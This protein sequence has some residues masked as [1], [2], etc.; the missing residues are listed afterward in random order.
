MITLYTTED[1][2]YCKRLKARMDRAGIDYSEVADIEQIRAR[3]YTTVPQMR[4]GDLTYDYYEAID[5]IE[6][7]SKAKEQPKAAAAS[8]PRFLSAEFLSAYPDQ[9]A[10]M[11]PLGAFTYYRTYSRYLPEEGRRETW[12]ETVGRAV[13]YNV[14]LD[15]KH[16]QAQRL[17]LPMAWLKNEAQA[18]FDSIFNL[19]QFPSGRTLWTGNTL[20]SDK[21]PMSNFNCSFTNIEKWSDLAE[22]F[23]LLMLG[24][25]VGF[26]CTPQMAAGLAPIRTDVQLILSPYHPVEVDYR[27]ENTDARILENGFA[28]IYVG[29]SKEGWR[30]ALMAYFDLLTKHEHEHIHTIKVSFNSVRPRG[31]RLKTF[32]GTASGPEPLMEMF[33]GFDDALKN[34]IDPHLAP[35]QTDANGYGQVRPIHI[36]DMGNLIGSN[37]VSG[38]VRRTAEL[39]L[40]DV[41]DQEVL[42]AK[43]GINGFWTPEHL[44]Q[45]HK[46]MAKMRQLGMTIPDWMQGFDAQ[47][48]QPRPRIGHRRLSNNSV[49][50]ESQPA[51]DFIDLV[52]L[53]L[54]LDGEPGFINLE[55]AGR[56]RDNMQAS[57][58]APRYCWTTSSSAT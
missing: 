49:G 57:T 33:Q 51:Q 11:T 30:D 3:G 24:S 15:Y 41:S 17:P 27:L 8:M 46:V 12:K 14:G 4:L 20:V 44:A 23:Y 55:A 47:G 29:D 31:D 58:L 28:K 25:G 22:L 45:H 34:K 53:M 5:F 26:K 6:A 50:F 2:I 39:F 13:E 18:L 9:P 10:H 38:G 21:Y 40:F 43:Y 19:R 42:F 16:R 48:S 37:V 32:G 36:L 54:Q 1:C 7:L 52:F 35:I 56:R